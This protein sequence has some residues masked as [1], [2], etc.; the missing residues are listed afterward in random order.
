LLRERTQLALGAQ[1]VVEVLAVR[2]AFLQEEL[3]RAHRDLFVSDV[4]LNRCFGF[5]FRG[6]LLDQPWPRWSIR[7]WLTGSWHQ[8]PFVRYVT[9]RVRREQDARHDLLGKMPRLRRICRLVCEFFDGDQEKST[10]LLG[11]T[12]N[13]TG[14]SVENLTQTSGSIDIRL[15]RIDQRDVKRSARSGDETMVTKLVKCLAAAGLVTAMA[16]PAFAHHSFAA[17]FDAK[18]PVKLRGTVV[19]MEWINPHSWIHIDV[20]DP[21]TGKVERWMIEGG[22]P[23]ALLRRGWTKNS[24]PEGTEILVE[25][26]QAKDGANRANG[27]D[28][29]FPDGKKLFV[30]SSGTGAPD[31][32]PEK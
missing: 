23:N 8:I 1:P 26:F 10:G 5:C 21:A 32:R 13:P 6:G 30:G 15:R 24:L 18:R 25:G 16:A 9:L 19:K 7:L 11:G 12:H 4:R 28:I 27:R 29:T 14:K 2:A 22:A 20:K 3:V 31:E 17:E